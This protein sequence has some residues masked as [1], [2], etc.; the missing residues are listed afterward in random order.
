MIKIIKPST[1]KVVIKKVINKITIEKMIN[2]IT[3]VTGASGTPPEPIP[4]NL[5][6]PVITGVTTEGETLTAS[7]GTWE[8]QTEPTFTYSWFRSGEA[9]EG[10]DGHE[11]EL[12]EADVGST[13]TV[14][15]VATNTTGSSE[16]VESLP[17]DVIQSAVPAFT[18]FMQENSIGWFETSEPETDFVRVGD[19]VAEWLDRLG[20]DVKFTNGAS[21]NQPISGLNTLNGKNV[22]NFATGRRMF[23]QGALL[24]L[25]TANNTIYVVLNKPD[26]S[27]TQRAI[28]VGRISN[29]DRYAL[30]FTGSGVRYINT[31]STS[32]TSGPGVFNQNNPNW[33][34]LRGRKEGS[35]LGLRVNNEVESTNQNGINDGA[36]TQMTLGVTVAGA[37][38]FNADIAAL[39]FFAKSLTPEQDEIVMQYL[40]D[41]WG[42]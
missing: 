17:T 4:V 29:Q 42:V 36:A 3:I 39:L 20:R 21:V 8:S 10:A 24:D 16:P 27:L 2:H 26:S 35:T 12:V 30:S 31:G 19:N 18:T 11:Y 14:H 25:P 22:L 34:V 28:L 32:L 41:E 5:T 37:D 1:P 23:A 7:A 6:L 13:L 33:R 40:N 38:P 9:I 15:V